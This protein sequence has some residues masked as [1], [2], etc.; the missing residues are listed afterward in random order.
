MKNKFLKEVLQW[1]EAIAIA[2]VLAILIR[3]FLFEPVIIDGT[4]MLDTLE[5][6][7]RVI[8]NKITLTFNEPEPGDIVVIE[9]DPPYFNVLTFLNKS[10]L[11]KRLLPTVTGADYIKRIIAVEGD[12]VD[13]RDGYVYVNDVKLDEPY[14]LKE[15]VTRQIVT[16]MPYTVEEGK[17][18]VMGDNRGASRDSRT[19]GT[20]EEEQV[21]GK[22]SYRIWPLSKIGNVDGD[23]K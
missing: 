10:A 19:I 14:V 8:L 2:I 9:I 3:G 16:A 11:A 6:G 4:S 18:F 13:I 22:A 17:Y 15:G 5:N 1:I 21:L 7:D 20:I 12:T 23:W